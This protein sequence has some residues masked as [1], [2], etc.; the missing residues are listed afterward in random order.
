MAHIR[1][2]KSELGKIRG[3]KKFPQK[4][5][6]IG[7]NWSLRYKRRFSK[8]GDYLLVACM[9]KSGSTFLANVLSELTGY[10]Y[11]ALSYAY[12]RS[13]QNLYL[14]K[15]ID[16][17]SF[18]S[19]THLHLRATDSTIDLL[20]IFSIRPVILVR[21]I[22]DVVVSIRDHMFNEGYEFPTFFCDENFKDLDEKSQFDFIIEQGI[23]WYFNFYATWNKAIS[24]GR[25]EGLWLEY[26][27]VVSNWHKTLRTVIDFYGIKKTYEEIDHALKKTA[28]KNKKKIRFN[29]GVVGRSVNLLTKDQKDRILSMARFYPRIDFSKM[30]IPGNHVQ[31]A[32]K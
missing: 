26:E 21:N 31:I 17:Y 15:L 13:E 25:I 4:P 12:E 28:M 16:S 24:K 9:P 11:V 14:P 20:K 32:H 27:K 18:G 30:G 23:P 19:V 10:P 29:K 22:F 8:R 6:E 1:L 3:I 2:L 7:L 5:A